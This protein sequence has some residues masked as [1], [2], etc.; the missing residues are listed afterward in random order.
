MALLRSPQLKNALALGLLAAFFLAALVWF[1]AS[2]TAGLAPPATQAAPPGPAVT[3]RPSE[4][5]ARPVLPSHPTL[6]DEGVQLYWA[7]C[8]VCHGDQGQGLTPEWRTLI[9]QADTYCQLPGC[10]VD[11]LYPLDLILPPS[12]RPVIGRDTLMRFDD[13]GQLYRTILQTMPRQAPGTL[14]V[15]QAWPLTVYLLRANGALPQAIQLTPDNAVLALLH[16]AAQPRGDERPGAIL[17]AASL[18]LAGGLLAVR[19]KD[20]QPDRRPGFFHHLHPPTILA[21]QSRWR[22]TLG[23]GGLAV[24][25]V[26]VLAVTG[27][28]EMFF[29]IPT[30]EQAAPSIQ[31]ITYLIPY[32]QLV[33]YL[34]YWAAQALV[35]VAGLHLLRVIFTGATIRR[36]NYLLGMTLFILALCMDFTGYMLR[37]DEGVRWPLVAG[38]NLLRTI[39]LWGNWL[40]LAAVGGE[41]PGAATL[42]RF[43]TWHVFGLTLGL[44]ALMAWHIFKVR[45]DGGLVAPPAEQR[46]TAERVTRFELVRREVVMALLASAALLLVATFAAAPLAMQP[47][48]AA[49]LPTADNRA[50]WFFLWVQQLL[51]WGNPFWLGVVVPL[52][53]LLLTGL[54]PYLLPAP[55]PSEL[56]RWFPRGGRLAQIAA[57]MLVLGVLSL[58]VLS[59]LAPSR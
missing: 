59:L 46:P 36:F 12:V 6:A 34:H 54:L 23:A 17:L 9:N 16:R 21:A 35:A 20:A 22:Y 51:R 29:Y 13:G 24:F 27:A 55:R 41:Q 42:I 26:L 5:L 30:P 48:K 45:R 25:L 4:R 19:A 10:D 7:N 57:V 58:T 38:T 11:V 14:T 53:A 47:I 33:R 52:A 8:M 40:Y 39:P 37:W 1:L 2:W 3:L 50:P 43:Y 31:A 49:A 44:V 28:L 32:G 15:D 56:G 18:A